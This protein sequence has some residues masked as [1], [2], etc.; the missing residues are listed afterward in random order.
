MSTYAQSLVNH[1]DASSGTTK[2]NIVIQRASLM[3]DYAEPVGTGTRYSFYDGSML[4]VTADKELK[5][6]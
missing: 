5:V 4:F 2:L 3:A 6:L 1:V